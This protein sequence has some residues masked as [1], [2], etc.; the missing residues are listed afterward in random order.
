MAGRLGLVA[1]LATVPAYGVTDSRRLLWSE[2]LGRLVVTVT[3]AN[4]DAFD[5]ALSGHVCSR[6]GQIVSRPQ[7]VVLH[8]GEPVLDVDVD[9][10]V[11][12]WKKPFQS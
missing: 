9:S 6:I 4:A 7:V 11:Q 2:S 8:G 1:D 3:P 12:A 5:R 10:C